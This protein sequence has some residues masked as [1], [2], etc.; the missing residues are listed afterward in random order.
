MAR[1]PRVEMADGVHHVFARGNGRQMIF[2]DDS[3]RSLYLALLARVVACKRWRC[4]AYCLMDN[5]VHLLIETPVPNLGPGMQWLHSRFAQRFNTCHG[6]T[7]HVFE[8]RFGSVLMG[9]DAQL[10]T[11]AAYIA[12]N[13]VQAGLCARPTDWP[14]SSHRAIVD[15]VAIPFLD[16]QRLLSYYDALGGDR[17]RRYREVVE[18][19]DLPTLSALAGSVPEE[20]AAGGV[21]QV[22]RPGRR[23]HYDPVALSPPRR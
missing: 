17:L 1:K 22:A 23:R 14:W 13:P 2:L 16:Q 19:G 7:G 11:A 5:H 18:R 12:R 21:A 8:D 6:R 15:R 10:W 20:R 4:L 9:S 3:D